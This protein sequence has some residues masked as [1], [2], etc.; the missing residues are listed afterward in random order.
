MEMLSLSH[1]QISSLQQEEAE[2]RTSL[3]LTY[4]RAKGR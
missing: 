1:D 2:N 3:L 4:F